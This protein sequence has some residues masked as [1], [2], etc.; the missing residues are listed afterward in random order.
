MQSTVHSLEQGM[1][2]R[3][4]VGEGVTEAVW[5]V[6]SVLLGMAVDHW[7]WRLSVHPT[8]VAAVYPVDVTCLINDFWET[9]KAMSNVAVDTGLSEPDTI[10]HLNTE[11]FWA[12]QI[13]LWWWLGFRVG[14]LW[15]ETM[16]ILLTR[17]FWSMRHLCFSWEFLNGHYDLSFKILLV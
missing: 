12:F 11:A 6:L 14:F 9:V 5:V 8:R 1:V 10:Q 4:R 17:L 13:A 3:G 7:T 15:G 16:W 2:S